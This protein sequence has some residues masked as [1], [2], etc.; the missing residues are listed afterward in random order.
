MAANFRLICWPEKIWRFK[1]AMQRLPGEIG[2]AR[3]EE[4]QRGAK[5]DSL[6]IKIIDADKDDK[7]NG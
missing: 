1:E 7:V 5:T 3:A 6:M 4:A 2:E